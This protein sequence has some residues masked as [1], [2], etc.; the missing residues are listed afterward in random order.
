MNSLF[1][2]SAAQKPQVSMVSQ[3]AAHSTRTYSLKGFNALAVDGPDVLGYLFSSEFLNNCSQIVS[4][5]I[6]LHSVSSDVTVVVESPPFSCMQFLWPSVNRSSDTFDFLPTLLAEQGV[7]SSRVSALSYSPEFCAQLPLCPLYGPDTD[8]RHLGYRDDL[9]PDRPLFS[10]AQQDTTCRVLGDLYRE[11]NGS[12]WR[13]N[14]GWTLAS[15]G[16]SASYCSFSG[17]SCYPPDGGSVTALCVFILYCTF[18]SLTPLRSLGGLQL[19][20]VIPPSLGEI[21]SLISMYAALKS[22]A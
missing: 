22:I 11:T 2:F 15:Q 17:V 7:Q 18:L 14:N 3:S 8:S 10:C 13:K 21:A 19:S 12:S 1:D 9:C 20:G 16:I 4:T 5:D 6:T